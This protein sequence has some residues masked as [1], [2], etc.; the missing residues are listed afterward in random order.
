MRISSFGSAADAASSSTASQP[1]PARES[2][3]L[4]LTHI[5]AEGRMR[6]EVLKSQVFRPSHRLPTMSIEEFGELEV[7]R[8]KEAEA[9]R[10]EKGDEGKP[11]KKIAQLEE[12][13]LED[14]IDLVNK[15]T[16]RDRAWD[17]WKDDNT[18]GAGVTK[19][20]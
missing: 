17:N 3:G 19:Y 7:Q 14:D 1:R 5:D 20:F 4:V 13:G 18:K 9:R 16:V 2:K 15:A 10:K 12:E 8:M 6:R 11:D